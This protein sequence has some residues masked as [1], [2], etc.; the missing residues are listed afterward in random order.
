[1]RGG[2]ACV[3]VLAA[4]LLAGASAPLPGGALPSA[5][6]P[7][8]GFAAGWVTA[9]LMLDGVGVVTLAAPDAPALARR[10]AEIRARLRAGVSRDGTLRMPG[11]L[12]AVPGEAGVL[13][14]LGG[15]PLLTLTPLDAR[16][17]GVSGLRDASVAVQAAI[18][19]FLARL[20]VGEAWQ[21]AL[22]TAADERGRPWEPELCAV[23][24][25]EVGELVPMGV[26]GIRASLHGHVLRLTGE[27][28]TL[29]QKVVLARDARN[30]PGVR[31]VDN[32]LVVR[33]GDGD[34]VFPPEASLLPDAAVRPAEPASGGQP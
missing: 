23:A 25:R 26:P 33:G 17:T 24:V 2:Q 20:P 16:R 34:P 21:E 15:E 31:D 12:A 27:V 8:N 5:Q 10:F 18:D 28:A 30:L 29:E 14:T 1:M 7:A 13:Y 9:R 6:L 3:S 19:A 4:F 32:M 22:F 11:T